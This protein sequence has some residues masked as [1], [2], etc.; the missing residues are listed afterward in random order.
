MIGIKTLQLGI[1]VGGEDPFLRGQLQRVGQR[2]VPLA[3]EL[4]PVD[5][6]AVRS[7][8]RHRLKTVFQIIAKRAQQCF[9][10]LRMQP[11]YTV[12]LVSFFDQAQ[13]ALA[14]PGIKEQNP[15]IHPLVANEIGSVAVDAVGAGAFSRRWSG[16]ERFDRVLI[17]GS[18]PVWKRLA[19]ASLGLQDQVRHTAAPLVQLFQQP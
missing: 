8:G 16:T 15:D 12:V 19:I 13:P 11:P 7:I 18:H 2:I 4:L 14:R 9:I 10:S 1:E 5:N 17:H 6:T 3:Q